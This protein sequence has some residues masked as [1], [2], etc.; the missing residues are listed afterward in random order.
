M[1]LAKEVTAGVLEPLWQLE[2]EVWVDRLAIL[3]KKGPSVLS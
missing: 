3:Q 1:Q 2:R